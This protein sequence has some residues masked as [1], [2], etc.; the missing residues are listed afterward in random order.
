VLDWVEKEPGEKITVNYRGEW[1]A[2][3]GF[4]IYYALRLDGG[5][6]HIVC[7]GGAWW[8][9]GSVEG[10]RVGRADAISSV[11]YRLEYRA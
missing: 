2:L 3:V 4:C 9:E 8:E 6:G 7:D 10:R 1:E 5:D 11:P